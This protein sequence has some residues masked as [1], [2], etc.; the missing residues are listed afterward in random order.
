MM[1]YLDEFEEYRAR[2]NSGG[3]LPGHAFR[4]PMRSWS[5]E[6]V[7]NRPSRPSLTTEESGSVNDLTSRSMFQTVGVFLYPSLEDN[8]YVTIN[9]VAQF[10]FEACFGKPIQVHPL[11]KDRK[12]SNINTLNVTDD[13]VCQVQ[14]DD[15]DTE[16]IEDNAQ[17]PDPLMVPPPSAT[18]RKAS[19][20]RLKVF[21]SWDIGAMRPRISSMPSSLEHTGKSCSGGRRA[22][23]CHHIHTETEMRRV[24]SFTI[25]PRGAKCEGELVVSKNPYGRSLPDLHPAGLCHCACSSH[26]SLP[27]SSGSEES[28]WCSDCPLYHVVLW[29]EEQVGKSAL[30]HAFSSPGLGGSFGK[31][32]QLYLFQRL[33]RV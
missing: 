4:S 16:S 32:T 18:A 19:M 15:C 9:Q 31:S 11:P 3:L 2:A 25:T 10:Q 30:I 5:A 17:V 24:R 6:N 22:S 27:T 1:Q 14:L 33:C 28:V 7:S 12:I 21:D 13:T 20:D 26:N 29:G 23:R 8:S